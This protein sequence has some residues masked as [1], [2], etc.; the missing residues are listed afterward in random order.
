MAVTAG[1]GKP[2]VSPSTLYSFTSL[3]PVSDMIL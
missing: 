1:G 3:L 2:R